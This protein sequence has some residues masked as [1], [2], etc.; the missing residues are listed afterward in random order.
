MK[1]WLAVRAL[2]EH[3]AAAAVREHCVARSVG[4][5]TVRCLTMIWDGNSQDIA[6]DL[7]HATPLFVDSITL[8]YTVG[9]PNR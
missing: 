2:K 7:D 3:D 4:G 6:Q 1:H 8:L 9:A 5:T